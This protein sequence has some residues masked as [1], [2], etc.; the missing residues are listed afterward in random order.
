MYVL[1]LGLRDEIGEEKSLEICVF[2]LPLI[3]SKKLGARVTI[4][5]FR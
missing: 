5:L 3:H 4:S 2:Q 1:S